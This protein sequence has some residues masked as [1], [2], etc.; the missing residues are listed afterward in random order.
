MKEIRRDFLCIYVYMCICKFVRYCS[1]RISILLA[2]EVY[3]RSCMISTINS[4]TERESG[5][6]DQVLW[7]LL[8][9]LEVQD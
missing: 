5:Q 8:L 3:I 9:Y 6:M 1:T 2:F 7:L 4:I